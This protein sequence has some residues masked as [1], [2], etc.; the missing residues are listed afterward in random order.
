M[1]CTV[2]PTC[3]TSYSFN[4]SHFVLAQVGLHQRIL[5]NNFKSEIFRIKYEQYFPDTN[6]Y[7]LTDSDWCFEICMLKCLLFLDFTYAFYRFSKNIFINHK[8]NFLLKF[9]I[10]FRKII[11]IH[12]QQ[13]LFP[14]NLVFIY[15]KNKIIRKFVTSKTIVQIT[16]LIETRN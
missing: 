6:F 15:F 10:Q 8:K 14:T 3:T 13:N 11:P 4:E 2:P 5:Q 12:R 9:L 7:K 16:S 1:I